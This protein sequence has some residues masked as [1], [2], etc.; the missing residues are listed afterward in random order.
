MPFIPKAASVAACQLWLVL[1]FPTFAQEDHWQDLNVRISFLESRQDYVKAI[2]LAE[3]ALKFAE[4]SFGGA[5]LR[6]FASLETLGRLYKN[7][8]SYQAAEQPYMRAI[9]VA[10][11]LKG[12]EDPNVAVGQNNL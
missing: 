12:P 4:A 11:E 10:S 9:R 8:G 2:P 3:E 1:S 5:D 6:V 7:S